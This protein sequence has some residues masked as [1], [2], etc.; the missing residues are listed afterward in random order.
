V[1]NFESKDYGCKFA[2][3]SREFC[4]PELLHR[5]ISPVM[6]L[7]KMF[8]ACSPSSSSLELS[9]KGDISHVSAGS[10]SSWLHVKTPSTSGRSL[11]DSGFGTPLTPMASSTLVIGAPRRATMRE[12]ETLPIPFMCDYDEDIRG[13]RSSSRNASEEREVPP[14]TPSGNVTTQTDKRN[15]PV[16]TPLGRSMR[17]L[18]ISQTPRRS[19][20]QRRAAQKSVD[21]AHR[22]KLLTARE[23]RAGSVQHRPPLMRPGFDL[24]GPQ[25]NVNPFAYA[26]AACSISPKLESHSTASCNLDR[27]VTNYVII[28]RHYLKLFILLN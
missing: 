5:V 26:S 24:S 9:N 7:C 15:Y 13:A 1:I 25:C 8:D 12:C 10:C 20:L 4:E 21:R 27:Q 18:N 2:V 14:T 16:S 22:I 19:T 23:R 3:M 6:N 17:S 28:L 11:W